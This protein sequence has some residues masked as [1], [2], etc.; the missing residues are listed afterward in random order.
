MKYASFVEI[1][2]KDH[3]TYIYYLQFDGNE[4]ELLALKDIIDNADISGMFGDYSEFCIDINN[5]VSQ[6]TVNEQIKI[7]FNGYKPFDVC[8]GKFDFHEDDFF[9]LDDKEKA[10][11][12]DEMFY[13]CRIENYF[14]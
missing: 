1:N 2:H 4:N 8:N 7:N 11:K 6:D 14:S 13:A 3:E 5:L 9:N 12:L 10:L